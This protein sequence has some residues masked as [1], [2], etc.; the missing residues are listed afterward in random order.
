MKKTSLIL[1]LTIT[2]GACAGDSPDGYSDSY[3]GSTANLTWSSA[4][5]GDDQYDIFIQTS[6]GDFQGVVSG[7]GVGDLVFLDSSADAPSADSLAQAADQND[8]QRAVLPTL[9]PRLRFAVAQDL[10]TIGGQ[11]VYS[12][13][14]QPAGSAQDALAKATSGLLSQ[15][16]Q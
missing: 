7:L 15:L 1:L 4:Q 6:V 10:E 14:L 5:V 11:I 12:P 13:P 8:L 16:Q 9:R 3:N 2:L